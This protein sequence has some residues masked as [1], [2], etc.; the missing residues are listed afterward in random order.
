MAA[1]NRFA[2]FL[3]LTEEIVACVVII[4]LLL[5]LSAVVSTAKTTLMSL[6]S[7]NVKGWEDDR[8]HAYRRGFALMQEPEKMLAT[9]HVAKMFVNVAIVIFAAYTAFS[10]FASLSAIVVIIAGVM[11]V[12]LVFAE[13]VPRWYASE[14]ALKILPRLS[15]LFLILQKIFYPLTVT[16]LWS[17]KHSRKSTV[18]PSTTCLMH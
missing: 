15:L 17:E 14:N 3:P 5:V 1:N 13:I 9:L 6:S 4:I 10:I 8:R 7:A 2:T 11:F 12:L 16:L 18:F